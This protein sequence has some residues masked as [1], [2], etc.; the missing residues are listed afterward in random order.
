[1]A[2]LLKL[3]YVIVGVGLTKGRV[4]Q[5]TIFSRRVR[6]LVLSCA[7]LA[8]LAYVFQTA[9]LDHRHADPS[10]AFGYEG[11]SLH[12]L[13]CHGDAASCA[14]SASL[15]G[16]L[17]QVTLTPL[18]PSSFQYDLPFSILAPAGSAGLVPDEPPRAA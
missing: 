13:H 16:S 4:M 15:S 7:R 18:V 8:L 6:F 9:A 1:M 12:A 2:L 10:D 17:A 11:S 14:D 3:A 5:A